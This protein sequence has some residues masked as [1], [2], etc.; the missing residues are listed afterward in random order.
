MELPVISAARA[1]NFNDMNTNM[2]SPTTRSPIG[3]SPSVSPQNFRLANSPSKESLGAKMINQ[4]SFTTLPA[5]HDLNNMGGGGGMVKS[6]S[7]SYLSPVV[8]AAREEV[9][10]FGFGEAQ[11]M[12]T[13]RDNNISVADRALNMTVN[14]SRMGSPMNAK[15]ARLKYQSFRRGKKSVVPTM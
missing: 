3:R 1:I 13:N 10:N 8:K 12:M 14:G 11:T 6:G 15:E 2:L 9:R 5:T 7:V 4:N